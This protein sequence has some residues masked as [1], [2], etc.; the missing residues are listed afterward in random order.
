[1][2][3][4]KSDLHNWRD[5]NGQRRIH[6]GGNIYL[7]TPIELTSKAMERARK[8]YTLTPERLNSVS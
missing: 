4:R 1:M 3:P 7:V 6:A 5:G 2:F 8:D